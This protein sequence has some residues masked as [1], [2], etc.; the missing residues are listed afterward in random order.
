MPVIRYTNEV[1]IQGW[2]PAIGG[3]PVELPPAFALNA[4]A[5]GSPMTSRRQAPPMRARS[6][7]CPDIHDCSFMPRQVQ[8]A[9]NPPQ[10]MPGSSMTGDSDPSSSSTSVSISTAS[11]STSSR[12]A[13][14]AGR[15]GSRPRSSTER[16]IARKLAENA[17]YVPRPKNS[18]ILFRTEFVAARTSGAASSGNSTESTS[19]SDDDDDEDANQSLS[20]QASAVWNKMSEAEKRPYVE[21]AKLEKA[22]HEAKYPHYRYK[23]V[24]HNSARKGVN[25]GALGKNAMMTG[26]MSPY[27]APTGLGL[28]RRNSEPLTHYEMD[29][30]ED[31]S[32]RNCNAMTLSEMSASAP[33][34]VDS[35]SRSPTPGSSNGGPSLSLPTIPRVPVLTFN[36]TSTTGQTSR[37]TSGLPP[38]P[39]SPSA[40]V[41]DRHVV[42]Q[43]PHPHHFMQAQS[44]SQYLT[45]TFSIPFNTSAASAARRASPSISPSMS[46][47]HAAEP[48]Y[49]RDFVRCEEEGESA[50]GPSNSASGLFMVRLVFLLTH[51]SRLMGFFLFL[52]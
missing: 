30:S 48:D 25:G 40:P 29:T 1:E 49:F 50:A 6:A 22:A 10:A 9:S 44:H 36:N 39:R 17:N 45:P 52:E 20:K 32:P 19:K 38:I 21:R 3:D 41:F 35:D 12:N 34:E 2:E 51:H 42:G 33:H 18:F 24:R 7:T 37:T 8:G 47:A 26:T 11:T 43:F 16:K 5:S 31:G 15:S 28:T 46:S 23:P 27:Q 14:A 13:A 4:N